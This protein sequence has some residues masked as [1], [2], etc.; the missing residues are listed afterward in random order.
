MLHQFLIGLD[1]K[2]FGSVVSSLLMMDP[3]PSVSIVYSKIVSDESKQALGDAQEPHPSDVGFVVSG[4][5]QG[6]LVDAKQTSTFGGNMRVCTHCGYKG[7]EKE[8]FF[9]LV[10]FL[11]WYVSM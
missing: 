11:E 6:R 7:H 4:A 8:K 2:I 10:G 5:A 1:S 9:E 3:L